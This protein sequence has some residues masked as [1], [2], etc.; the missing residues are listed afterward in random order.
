MIPFGFNRAETGAPPSGIQYVGGKM[1]IPTPGSSDYT[2][3]LTGLSGGLASSAADGDLVLVHYGAASNTNR[4][5]SMVIGASQGWTATSSMFANETTDANGTGAYKFMGGTPDTTVDI[6]ATSQ[7]SSGV[8]VGIQVWRGVDPTTPMDQ[9]Q[10]TATADPSR[11]ANPP[12]I[13]PVTSGAVVS[14]F[15]FV[16]YAASDGDLTLGPTTGLDNAL[17]ETHVNTYALAAIMGSVNWS[18]SGAVDPSAV[19][20]TGTVVGDSAAATCIALRPA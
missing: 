12:S 13:T 20:I 3:D 10:T 4:T 19:S 2:L 11:T 8:V 1:V 6:G 7:S 15:G 17:Q 14:V 9:T 5:G 18:G 16:A